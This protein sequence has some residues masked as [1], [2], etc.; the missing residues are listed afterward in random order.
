MATPASGPN[1]VLELAR[2][3][4][5]VRPRDLRA[6]GIHPEHLRRL[7]ESG[8]MTRVGRGLYT[9]P[10]ADHSEH[11]SLV[12][13][14]KRVPKGIVCLISALEYHGLGTQIAHEVWMM[15]DRKAHKPRARRPKMR[16]V[17]ASG[18]ALTAG[19][20][21]VTIEGVPVRIT[22]VPKTVADCFRYRSH[23]GLDVALEALTEC[24]RQRR[25]TPSD[26]S[27]Y[28]EVCGVSTVMRPYLEALS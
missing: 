20:E 9:L 12:E 18:K 14:A 23:V 4:G 2:R 26:L 15:I 5:V 6:R 24:L 13:A 16:F 10:D 25:S 22:N 11:L 21:E 27:Q 7:C 17:L 8:R 28:A 1:Q 3:Q 19:V